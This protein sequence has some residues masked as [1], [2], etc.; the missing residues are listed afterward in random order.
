MNTHENRPGTINKQKRYKQTD[1]QNL[2]IIYRLLS[3]HYYYHYYR[4]SGADGES[5]VLSLARVTLTRLAFII[6]QTKIDMLVL[7]SQPRGILVDNLTMTSDL[8]DTL[9]REPGVR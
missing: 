2:P 5:F 8:A 3:Y 7:F 9:I 1:T 6:V 4:N